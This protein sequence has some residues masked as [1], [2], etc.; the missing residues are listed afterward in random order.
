MEWVFVDKSRGIRI[1]T[2]TIT[3]LELKKMLSHWNELVVGKKIFHFP[4]ENLPNRLEMLFFASN[5]IRSQIPK[6]MKIRRTQHT[7]AVA[8][9]IIHFHKSSES[10]P[11]GIVPGVDKR[12]GSR[13][14]LETHK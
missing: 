10:F 14:T 11:F 5:R 2:N 13:H 6:S 8:Q 9:P 7:V 1:N 4:N 3:F 12:H